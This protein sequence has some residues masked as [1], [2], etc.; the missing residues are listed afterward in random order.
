M[1]RVSQG[2]G[3]VLESLSKQDL[4]KAQLGG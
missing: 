4:A 1:G 3:H 2:G